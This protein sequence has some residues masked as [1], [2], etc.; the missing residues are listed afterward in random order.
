MAEFRIVSPD[1]A[2]APQF[3]REDF[4]AAAEAG[5]RTIINNRPDG[6][7]PGQ[8]SSAEAEAAALAAGLAYK[9]L[10]FTGAPPPNVVA[11]TAE[12]LETARGPVLAYCRTGT[13]SVTAWAFARALMDGTPD[14]I[15]GGAAR[16]GYDLERL[17]P[18]LEE[19]ARGS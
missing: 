18:I 9:A 19:M 12:L 5:F 17:R 10:P 16:A 4:A 6:E 15:L 1:F 2:V 3:A 11:E 13:R 7:T 14:E 8:L